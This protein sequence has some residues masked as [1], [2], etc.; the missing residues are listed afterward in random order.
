MFQHEEG[1][2]VPAP[3]L[4][5][6][7]RH[8]PVLSSPLSYGTPLSTPSH[9]P[10][11]SPRLS[12]AG[13]P[14]QPAPFVPQPRASP[15]QLQGGPGPGLDLA[16]SQWPEVVLSPGPDPEV[17]IGPE[18]E[19]EPSQQE[20]VEAITQLPVEDTLPPLREL[21]ETNMPTLTYIPP[22][23]CN[24]WSRVLGGLWGS[25]AADMGNIL[26]WKM[27]TVLPFVIFPAYKPDK[28]RTRRPNAHLT[29]TQVI[30]QRLERWRAGEVSELYAEA[31]QQT[32]MARSGHR[33]QQMS[34]DEVKA[35]NAKKATQYAAEGSLSKAMEILVSRGLAQPTAAT[36][37]RM[38][39]LHPTEPPPPP[40]PRRSRSCL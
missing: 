2:S 38:Q 26:L 23:V 40:G 8:S 33:R 9:T 15:S 39:A 20:P 22:A 29:Q 32:R 13:L 27:F 1:H 3:G 17:V 35:H 36:R 34:E 31:L 25:L 28:R 18:P 4:T 5:A 7:P 6:S 14:F 10:E 24:M 37:D 11:P 16:R 21:Y 19:V 12:E 30:L